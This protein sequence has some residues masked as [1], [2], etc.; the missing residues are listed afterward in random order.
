MVF[1]RKRSKRINPENSNSVQRKENNKKYS[2]S[3]KK[4]KKLICEYEYFE[5]ENYEVVYDE[6]NNNPYTVLKVRHFDFIPISEKENDIVS[7]IEASTVSKE[8]CKIRCGLGE[9]NVLL[10]NTPGFDFVGRVMYSQSNEINPGERV[11]SFLPLMGG[12]ARYITI[13]AK[14]IV[15]LPDDIDPTEVVC[16][17]RSYVMAFHC[18]FCGIPI[19]N[20]RYNNSS[21]KGKKILV[22]AGSSLIGQATI[23]LALA[24]GADV[25]ATEKESQHEFIKS[26]GAVPLKPKP[27]DWL[28]VVQKKMDIVIDGVCDDYFSSPFQALKQSKN[29]KL[30][31]IGMTAQERDNEVPSYIKFLIKLKASMMSNTHM[32][33]L[34]DIWQ[35]KTELCK[36]DLLFLVRLLKKDVIK[37]KVAGRIPLRAVV[38][39]HDKLQHE[40]VDGTIVCEPWLGSVS[41]T[42]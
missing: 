39:A 6:F 5:G 18:L 31:C 28:P 2:K 34:S 10:P 41:L 14:S 26:L 35:E 32:I 16:L 4:E 40:D 23:Q 37:P 25:M 1:Y 13:S 33:T 36:N 21:L 12:N 42:E 20:R 15:K 9:K 17:I 11:A 38:Y 19:Y 7:I 29:S 8:D 24:L 3:M 27:E 30:I 22:T